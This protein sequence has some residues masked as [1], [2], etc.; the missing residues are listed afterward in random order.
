MSPVVGKSRGGRCAGSLQS[1][2]PSCA[3]AEVKFEDL[4]ELDRVKRVRVVAE[5]I[6]R[7]SGRVECVALHVLRT[8]ELLIM[9]THGHL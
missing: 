8:F 6:M 3:Q 7:V 2:V 4:S 9:V 5:R 1:K